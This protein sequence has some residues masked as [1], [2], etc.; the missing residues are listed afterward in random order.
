MDGRPVL[1]VKHLLCRRGR[2]V[3]LH[4][5]VRADDPECFHTH[6]AVAIR[7]ILWGGYIEEMEDGRKRT[8]F[9]GRIG[10]VN[11]DC[12]HRISE[13]RNGEMSLSLWIRFQKTQK[14]KLRGSGW[15]TSDMTYVSPDVE[16]EQPAIE[17]NQNGS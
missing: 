11:P 13:L 16:L 2:H 8:W 6:P 3:D 17:E 12:S 4:K 1:W 9:P 7:I 15:D 10:I 14:T 5:M